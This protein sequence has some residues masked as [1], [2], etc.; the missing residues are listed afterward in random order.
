MEETKV[1]ETK[2]V[3]PTYKKH[4]PLYWLIIVVGMTFIVFM[5]IRI[6][7][8]IAEE[9]IEKEDGSKPSTVTSNSNSNS[10]EQKESEVTDAEKVEINSLM[11]LLF[12]NSEIKNNNM[13]AFGLNNILFGLFNNF[14]GTTGKNGKNIIIVA[15][16]KKED[17]I[18]YTATNGTFKD[19][20]TKNEIL[21]T[22]KANNETEAI[23]YDKFNT[24]YKKLFNEDASTEDIIGICP[25]W[26]YDSTNKMFVAFL[27]CGG[28]DF[29][30]QIAYLDSYS[31][32]DDNIVVTTYVAGVNSLSNGATLYTDAQLSTKYKDLTTE[33]FNKFE[34]DET[35]KTSF[36]KYNFTFAKNTNGEYYFKS[37]TKAN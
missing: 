20:K 11:S 21:D 5:S 31:K 13:K 18:K 6:G 33:E 22:I 14:E 30:G 9:K 24:Y 3:K 25:N 26:Y 28:V 16:M 7:E 29:K 23:S 1:E 32:V 19:D 37:L 8:K 35:N 10:N 27:G 2:E 36:T 34:I 4:G 15:G 17:I 12:L